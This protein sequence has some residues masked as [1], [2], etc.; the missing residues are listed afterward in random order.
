VLVDAG[1]SGKRV[2]QLLNQMGE[3]PR[4]VEAILVTHDHIDH[5]SGIGVLSR[6]FDIPVFAN[7]ATWR[8]MEDKIGE[9]SSRN[10]RE[11]TTGGEF[12]LAGFGIKSFPISHDASDP[13]GFTFCKGNIKISVAND[14]GCVTPDVERELK[15]SS[16][17]MLEANHDTEMLWVG[18]Y[19]WHLK[20]RIAGDRGH[21][22]NEDTGAALIRLA[23][24]RTKAVLLGHL[25]KENNYP[26]LA[27]ET[28]RGI[29]SKEGIE[30]GR[31]MHIDLSFRDKISRIYTI[32]DRE[33]Y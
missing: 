5:I 1:L 23:G 33:V 21:L 25:S 18:R 3:T 15:D 4:A 20:R 13:V 10:I 27:L 7:A 2:A 9:I 19:P 16:F 14:L 24:G 22:S 28:V 32:T 12:E 6:R 29:L 11:F 17:I 31:E 8:A 26:L 30:V